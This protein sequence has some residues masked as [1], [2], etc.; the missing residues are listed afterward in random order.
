M[1]TRARVVSAPATRQKRRKMI[2]DH[3]EDSARPQRA[4]EDPSNA[5]VKRKV[6]TAAREHS[7]PRG[8]LPPRGLQIYANGSLLRRMCASIPAIGGGCL[9]APTRR[10][11]AGGADGHGTVTAVGSAARGGRDEFDTTRNS[12]CGGMDVLARERS[13][14]RTEYCSQPEKRGTRDGVIRSEPLRR[15]PLS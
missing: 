4:A 14:R 9:R 8:E 13:T 5:S 10:I 11:K 7:S 15:V 6:T 2:N 1:L 12:N 3:F